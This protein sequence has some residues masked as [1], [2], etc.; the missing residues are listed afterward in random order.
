VG[1][2]I[3]DANLEV[4]FNNSGKIGSQVTRGQ[5]QPEQITRKKA[6]RNPNMAAS[7]NVL[8]SAGG[9]FENHRSLMTSK[10]SNIVAEVELDLEGYKHGGGHNSPFVHHSGMESNKISAIGI[11]EYARKDSPFWDNNDNIFELQ[12]NALYGNSHKG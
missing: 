9:K 11:P 8:P 7:Q 1:D 4:S 6:A 12:S 3:F 10:L 5:P 2:R